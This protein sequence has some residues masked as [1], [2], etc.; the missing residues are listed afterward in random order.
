VRTATEGVLC[1]PTGRRAGRGAYLCGEPACFERAR[2]THL[3]DRA[4][5]V[6]LTEADYERLRDGYTALSGEEVPNAPSSG[7]LAERHS[8][9][10]EMV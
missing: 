4:L 6:K 2:K 1:D 10:E 9:E 7:R 8:P 5:R 3:F